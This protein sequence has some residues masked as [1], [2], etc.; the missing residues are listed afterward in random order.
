MMKAPGGAI[1]RVPPTL[2]A[3]GA[4]LPDSLCPFAPRPLQALHH[5]YESVHPRP[6]LWYSAS[7]FSSLATSYGERS[8]GW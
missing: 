8:E 6:V 3:L 4:S 1:V 5:Y 2:T 7:R